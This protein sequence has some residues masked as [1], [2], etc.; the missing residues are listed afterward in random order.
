MNH[1]IYIIE[2]TASAR[3]YV[4]SAVDLENRLATHRS[5]L[6]AGKHKN[7][8]LQA[9]WAKYGEEAFAFAFLEFIQ[10][11]EQ[12]LE[13]EQGW[14]DALNCAVPQ[15]FNLAPVAGSSLGVVHGVEYR[16]RISEL[17]LGNKYRLGM[18]HSEETKRL[19]GEK[20]KG[21]YMSPESLAK[22]SAA[23]MGKR[24]ALG[25]RQSEEER[26]RRSASLKA[27]YAQRRKESA[28]G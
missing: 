10:H 20:S 4:G 18:R 22:R 24:N 12:L 8:F 21:R 14:I 15:G 7:R 2:H 3:R 27:Y 23:M 11:K 28:S 1:G 17:K 16:K 6:R 26:A 9:A 25:Y 19:I 13:A 5:Q